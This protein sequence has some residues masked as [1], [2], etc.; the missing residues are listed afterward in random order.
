[1]KI[2]LFF[3]NY[4]YLIRTKRVKSGM[5]RFGARFYDPQIGR[6][7]SIDPLVEKDRRW[8]PYNYCVDNPIRFIDLDGMVPSDP[9]KKELEKAIHRLGSLL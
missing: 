3:P 5:V 6:W 1:M 7:H 8:S 9:P 2:I 4:F